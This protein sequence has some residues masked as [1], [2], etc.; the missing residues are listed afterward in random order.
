MDDI[1]AEMDLQF[2]SL[3]DDYEPEIDERREMRES[4]Q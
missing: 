4:L 2:E 1:N 3:V